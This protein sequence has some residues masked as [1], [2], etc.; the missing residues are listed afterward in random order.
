MPVKGKEPVTAVV[1]LLKRYDMT[2]G[3]IKEIESLWE[4]IEAQIYAFSEKASPMPLLYKMVAFDNA[5]REALLS[6]YYSKET[7]EAVQEI[8]STLGV[9]MRDMLTNKALSGFAMEFAQRP[10]YLFHFDEAL[11]PIEES[12]F[13]HH[14][15]LLKNINLETHLPANIVKNIAYFFKPFIDYSDT[16][17]WS[18]DVDPDNPATKRAIEQIVMLYDFALA[19]EFFK[20]EPSGKL[21]FESMPEML[22]PLLNNLADTM[23]EELEGEA[24]QARVEAWKKII[25]FVICAGPDTFLTIYIDMLEE[26]RINEINMLRESIIEM[27]E[28]SNYNFFE[29]L[30]S[31]DIIFAYRLFLDFQ[32]ETL[33]SLVK[34]VAAQ[35]APEL[36]RD[37][38]NMLAASGFSLNLSK[39]DMEEEQ[40]AELPVDDEMDKLKRELSF[41]SE[42]DE[43][44]VAAF[45][46]LNDYLNDVIEFYFDKYGSTKSFKHSKQEII[47][48][49]FKT[50]LDT[51][52]ENQP[53]IGFEFAGH[54]GGELGGPSALQEAVH[55][56]QR[57]NSKLFNMLG[58]LLYYE[59][60]GD[61]Q[62]KGDFHDIVKKTIRK[63]P[64]MRDWNDD[65]WQ[66]FKTIYKQKVTEFSGSAKV[67]QSI[68]E[69][70]T[71]LA[72]AIMA[73]TE[74]VSNSHN[75]LTP[76][77]EHNR[78]GGEQHSAFNR[79]SGLADFFKGD[80]RYVPLNRRHYTYNLLKYFYKTI[81]FILGVHDH[82][83]TQT[84]RDALGGFGAMSHQHEEERKM[85]AHNKAQANHQADADLDKTE[86]D[87]HAEAGNKKTPRGD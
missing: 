54:F 30:E 77:I 73:L 71:K 63:A 70:D 6:E 40:I 24:K 62:A 81:K 32:D 20:E 23:H 49:S 34:E 60:E 48:E 87:E 7:Q 33:L 85:V 1:E 2:P 84:M 59:F 86:R 15:T 67:V 80:P 68:S 11:R 36:H 55:N 4:S 29:S 42:Y 19:N 14:Q 22:L 25:K 39:E 12:E 3:N 26:N 18:P 76:S 66:T 47:H 17:Q 41:V 45:I 52:E 44:E 64:G 38:K 50:M 51:L 53:L 9:T 57:E 46:W 65:H 27:N 72:A 74:V 82:T 69:K 79:D 31:E 43:L 5:L 10:D 56:I 28:D 16:W 61:D 13:S 21:I 35:R 78:D 58:T 83:N 37:E 75:T 8:F